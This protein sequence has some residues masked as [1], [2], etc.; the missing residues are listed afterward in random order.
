[1]GSHPLPWLSEILTALAERRELSGMQVTHIFDQMLGGHLAEPEVAAFLIAMRMKGETGG[2]LA[3]AA[4]VLRQ[5]M[6]RFETGRSDV[7]DTCGPGGDGLGTFNISTAA[8]LVAAGAG[9][10]VVKHGNRAVSSRSGSADVLAELGLPVEAGLE[11]A[12]RCLERAGLA[13]CFAPQFHPALKHL[14]PLRRRLGVRTTLN[15]LG[16]LANPAGA[17]Y[18]LVGV[19][20]PALLDPIAQALA[21]LEVR[22]AY[23]VCGSD[24]LDEVSLSGPSAFRRV[25]AGE[26]TAGEWS[27]A[28]FGLAPCSIEDLKAD[29]P[30]ASARVIGSV[31]AGEPSPAAR[32]AIANA[33]AALLAAGRAESLRDGVDQARQSIGSGKALRVLELMR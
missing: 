24:G 32:I 21:Q 23:V 9:V 10:P 19:C 27:P 22:Q 25:R 33:A 7:L 11:W 31:L 20:Q 15:L 13:F 12:K 5:Q 2:E 1:V 14:G 3:A 6:Q 30:A 8:A 17:A 26:V 28:D 29:G 18:Q 16:P 4:R